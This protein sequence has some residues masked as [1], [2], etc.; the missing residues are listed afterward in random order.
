MQILREVID[1]KFP[2]NS[3]LV[4]SEDTIDTSKLG[5]G[6]TVTTDTCN[7]AQK[8]RRI[9]SGL[10]PGVCYKYDYMHHICNVWFGSMEKAPTKTLNA[11]LRSD[12]D[13]TDPKLRVTAS[14]SAIIQAINK[15]FSLSANYPNSVN[16]C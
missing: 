16:G 6:A 10:I 14:I 3:H 13:G 1:D 2:G 9:L 8:L 5:H 15:E 11:I 12:L 4:P 7:A